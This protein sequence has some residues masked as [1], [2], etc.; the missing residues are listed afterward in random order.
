LDDS[1]TFADILRTCAKAYE[2]V[3]MKLLKF[4]LAR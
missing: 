3:D 1:W 4:P 2:K